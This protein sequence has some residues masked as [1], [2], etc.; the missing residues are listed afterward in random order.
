MTIFQLCNTCHSTSM[1]G[2]TGSFV[3]GLIGIRES[4]LLAT[5]GNC[6]QKSVTYLETF[7]PPNWKSQIQAM[8]LPKHLKTQ[9]PGMSFERFST[10][11]RPRVLN[12][13]F[14]LFFQFL[15]FWCS[16]ILANSIITNAWLRLFKQ[17]CV[18]EQTLR[19]CLLSQCLLAHHQVLAQKRLTHGRIDSEHIFQSVLTASKFARCAHSLC[20]NGK[21]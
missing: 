19:A 4:L 7:E 15:V 12:F 17:S 18:R 14:V 10:P 6:G 3:I 2:S 9:A 1:S 16:L 8:L 11:N 5:A 21:G 20:M 13:C